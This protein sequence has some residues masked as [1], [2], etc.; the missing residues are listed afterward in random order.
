MSRKPG[1][2][3][4]VELLVVIA[5]VGLLVAMLLPAVQAARETARRTQCGNN[6]RQVGVALQTFHDAKGYFPSSYLSQP[7]GVMGTADLN[8]DAGPG[9]TCLVQILPY[10]EGS[11]ERDAFD[12]QS[13]SWAP[14]NARP[15]LQVIPTYLCPSVSDSTTHYVVKDANGNPLADFAR[16]HYV[17]SAGQLDV[18]KIKDANLSR[19]ADGPL[20]R[21]SRTRI[22][23]IT[24]G[25][26]HTVFIGERTPLRSP[27]T[28]V[29][30][31]PGSVTCPGS[32]FPFADCDA[33]A[34][35]INVHSG[36]GK[37]EKLPLIEPPNNTSGYTDEMHS[38]HPTGCNVLFGDGS[39]RFVLETVNPL[40]WAAWAT[41]AGGE[42]IDGLE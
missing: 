40:L 31:V 20:Y 18:W 33:A 2:F 16:S 1:A 34:P 41:R 6:L 24:D 19:I 17:A 13:P 10:M 35:Q 42:T 25:T 15:A 29:A 14:V 26:T 28:W 21:N 30:I 39:V 9:W 32:L 8:G 4:L 36:P 38:E 22:K 27:A 11:N 5:I 37:F 7:G 23:D 12:L 3:T